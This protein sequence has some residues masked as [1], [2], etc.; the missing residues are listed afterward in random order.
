MCP[1]LFGFASPSDADQLDNIAD[2]VLGA[3]ED[4]RLARYRLIFQHLST[5]VMHEKPF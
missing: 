1:P 5:I 3:Q 2:D 4:L